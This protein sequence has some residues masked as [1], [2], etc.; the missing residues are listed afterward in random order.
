M[1]DLK[2]TNPIERKQIE[3]GEI[4]ATIRYDDEK[5]IRQTDTIRLVDG[6]EEPFAL[7][8]VS[9]VRQVTIEDAH[10]ALGIMGGR[11][12]SDGPAD[13]RETLNGYYDDPISQRTA[14]KV[15]VFDVL[16]AEP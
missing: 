2:F 14:V 8:Y 11:H 6:N 10:Q 9:R 16:D 5:G 15:I 4:N 3:Q 7:A 12:V 13:L 1:K